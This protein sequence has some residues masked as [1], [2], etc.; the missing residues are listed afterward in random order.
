VFCEIA[1]WYLWHVETFR[2]YFLCL[3]N[4]IVMFFCAMIGFGKL[5]A[6]RGEGWV[7]GVGWK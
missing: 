2:C 6:E 3:V 1:V 5:R 7:W 4:Q